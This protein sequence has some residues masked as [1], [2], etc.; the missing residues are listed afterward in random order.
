MDTARLDWEPL[1][2]EFYAR[3]SVV[4]A[5]ELIG[6]V[7]VHRV[8]SSALAGVIV[9]AEA[10]GPDD[11][12]SHAFRGATPR[13]SVMFGPPGHAY[14]YLSY[15]VHWCANA[16]TG[17]AGT[18]EAV[19]IRALEPTA[20]VECM[21]RNRGVRFEE[22]PSLDRSLCRGPGSLCRALGI[23]GDMNGMD[24]VGERLFV[25]FGLQGD[26]PVIQTTRI[27]L[28]K[29]A[30]VPWRFLAAGNPYVSRPPRNPRPE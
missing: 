6:C 15:G 16:V 24:L 11:P 13:N 26:Y 5:R 25:S 8:N 2:R 10:Y 3:D 7:L 19:L 30:D 4:V 14:I 22:D 12:A 18:G 27:G 20:G 17:S 29:A 21:R 23:A 28:T 9:E 1:P